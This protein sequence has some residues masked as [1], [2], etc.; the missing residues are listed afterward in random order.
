[1]SFRLL[2]LDYQSQLKDAKNDEIPKI[3]Q[4]WLDGLEK[5]V[6]K[7]GK[8]SY[9][10]EPMLALAQEYEIHSKEDD[11]IKWYDR[12]IKD[13]DKS[14]VSSKALGGKRRLES[15]GNRWMISGPSIDGKGSLTA[16]QLAGKV[17]VVQYWATWA[18]QCKADFDTL[19]KLQAKYGK[20]GFQV[21]GVNLDTERGDA[22]KVLKSSS[23][24]WPNLY[25]PG[26]FDSRFANEMG[27]FSLPLMILVD[28]Q[29]KVVSRNITAEELD[30]ELKKLLK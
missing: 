1:L 16:A 29:G 22:Q 19:K 14:E 2:Q 8:N 25:E 11:A 18:D 24:P 21:V 3:A 13:F 9:A 28:K 10:A 7:Y 12:I 30:G 27:V 20:Q 5:L 26:G 15:I 6:A 4:S 17:V 23:L